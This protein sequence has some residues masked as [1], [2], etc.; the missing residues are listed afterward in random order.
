M[1]V[2]VC[3][4]QRKPE[5]TEEWRT[6]GV[7]GK[8]CIQTAKG[9]EEYPCNVQRNEMACLEDFLLPVGV[10]E[11]LLLNSQWPLPPVALGERGE[12]C[13]PCALLAPPAVCV[14]CNAAAP[15]VA[16]ETRSLSMKIFHKLIRANSHPAVI[17]AHASAIQDAQAAVTAWRRRQDVGGRVIQIVSVEHDTKV[18]SLWSSDSD[19]IVECIITVKYYGD[20]VD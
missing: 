5:P 10:A 13:C 1:G 15:A 12:R 3:M 16:G 2:T 8:L 4:R 9:H 18:L 7:F 20:A 17:E 11:K 14:C 6:A 19:K